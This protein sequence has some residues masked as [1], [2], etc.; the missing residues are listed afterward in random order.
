MK[1]RALLF[2]ISNISII[3]V[4]AVSIQSV[5]KIQAG[6]NDNVSE[7][8]WSEKIGWVSF[9][10]TNQGSCASFDYG[11]DIEEGTGDL[12]GHA[13]SENIGWI[14]FNEA[15]LSGCPSGPCKASVDLSCPDHHCSVSGWA[16]AQISEEGWTGWIRL[17]DTDYE[18]WIDPDES[19]SEFRGWAW[20]NDFGW[21]DFNCLDQDSCASFDY[22]V[23][24]DFDFNIASVSNT[25]D[26]FD[27]PCS[28]SRVPVLSW[29][30]DTDKPYDYQIEIDDNADFSSPEISDSV[31]STNSVSWT[32]GCSK[33]CPAVPFSN[34]LWGGNTYHWRVRVKNII[35]PWSDWEEDGDGFLTYNHCFPFPDFL[36]DGANCDDLRISGG[37]E[38]TLSDDSDTYGGSSVTNCSWDLPA[39]AVVISGN[40]ASD[41]TLEVSYVAG[42][43]QETIMTV[44]DSDGYS[45]PAS[46]TIDILIPLPEW[47]EIA[48]F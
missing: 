45:C 12:S 35:G 3:V 15:D 9:N 2:L 44:T 1:K 34:I 30:T 11:V 23:L 20:S 22:K 13:W 14:T 37:R 47:S 39:D 7:W 33:C 10:C 48:P 36:C 24:T 32:P 8:A 4:F 46:K 41:C 18:V 29:Q 16:K 21:L 28:Q 38:F 40:P 31:L 26:S 27:A 17:K 43:N 42:P 5:K 6:V 25:S 19:L